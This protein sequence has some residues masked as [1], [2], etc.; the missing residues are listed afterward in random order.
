MTFY[1]LPLNKIRN[2]KAMATAANTCGIQL[3]TLLS[4]TS[5]FLE[6]VENE[7]RAPSFQRTKFS[8]LKMRNFLVILALAAEGYSVN[9]KSLEPIAEDFGIQ[10]KEVESYFER[11]GAS[12]KTFENDP[13]ASE[14]Q[15]WVLNVPIKPKTKIPSAHRSAKKQQ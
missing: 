14:A 11:V 1:Q 3:K 6:K 15:K 10:R 5:R 2:K 7:G 8:F 13:D 4:F 9:P 12:R